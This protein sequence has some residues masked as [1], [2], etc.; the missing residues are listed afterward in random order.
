MTV[1][2]SELNEPF[3]S[4][5]HEEEG[6]HVAE[7]EDDDQEEAENEALGVNGMSYMGTRFEGNVHS[8]CDV[9]LYR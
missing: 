8:S 5:S 3:K 9:G 1:D 7:D 4:E 6:K 2:L